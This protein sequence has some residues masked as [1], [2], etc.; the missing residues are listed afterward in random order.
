MSNTAMCNRILVLA[1]TGLIFAVNTRGLFY[2]TL[3]HFLEMVEGVPSKSALEC[4]EDQ[5]F[6]GSHGRP[7]SI[8]MRINC[9]F[10]ALLFFCYF[11]C[12]H[13]F[14]YPPAISSVLFLSLL[15]IFTFG[16]SNSPVEPAS[17][18][19]EGQGGISSAAWFG[20]VSVGTLN[21]RVPQLNYDKI[22][23]KMYTRVLVFRT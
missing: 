22:L 9:F 6:L 13:S 16:A 5:L 1:R 2:S 11:Y 12:Y 19:G 23:M 17:R 15:V 20:V 10:R 4:M 21:W 8:C 14:S 7:V 3:P 18:N